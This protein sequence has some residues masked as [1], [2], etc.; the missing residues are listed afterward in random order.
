MIQMTR[1]NE[2]CNRYF[3]E[4]EKRKI[5]KLYYYKNLDEVQIAEEMESLPNHITWCLLRWNSVYFV[6]EH[7]VVVEEST[8]E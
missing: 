5:L 3:T 7:R 2:Y 8:T 1:V 4:K 6:K